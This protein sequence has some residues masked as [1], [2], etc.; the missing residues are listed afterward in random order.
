MATSAKPIPECLHTLTPHLVLKDAARMIEF[1]RRA[2][3]AVERSRMD[4]PGVGI[5]HAELMIGDSVLFVAD[6]FP[7]APALAPATVGGTT[8]AVHIYV[9][10]A[11]AVFQRAVQAGAVATMPM[12]DTFWGDRYAQVTDPA[13]HVWAIATHVE[14]VTPEE[15]KQRMQEWLA[16]MPRA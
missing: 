5:A 4:M 15:M 3:G 6:E 8:S 2:F 10:D 11:D 13:G 7:K 9:P 1:Y 16:S 14:D 12:M